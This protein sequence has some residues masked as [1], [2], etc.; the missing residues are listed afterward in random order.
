MPATPLLSVMEM[1]GGRPRMAILA[2]YHG[3]AAELVRI[4]D[5]LGAHRV[6]IILDDLVENLDHKRILW[7]KQDLLRHDPEK[8]A[9]LIWNL[10]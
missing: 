10:L 8:L 7:E 9:E 3:E 6:Q 2:R 4:D 1:V 5:Q